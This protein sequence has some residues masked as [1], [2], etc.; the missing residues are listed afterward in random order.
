[1]NEK[2]A[3]VIDRLKS[4]RMELP[5]QQYLP[6]DVVLDQYEQEIGVE[7]PNDY[8]EFLKT[9][10]DSM[11]NGK[12]ALRVTQDKG[13]SSELAEA[14]INAQQIGVPKNW[15]PICEDNGDYFCI[16]PDARIVFWDH[17]GQNDESWPDLASWIEQV[18]IEGN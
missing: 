13:H 4:V 18:W 17:N 3:S 11:Y 15:I 16:V 8:R 7:F 2:L 12:A 5:I 10:S 1:M 9:A 6:D 14:I